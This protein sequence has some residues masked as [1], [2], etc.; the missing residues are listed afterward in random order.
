MGCEEGLFSAGSVKY[1]LMGSALKMCR[2][3][4]LGGLGVVASASLDCQPWAA[5]KDRHRITLE[6]LMPLMPE[7]GVLQVQGQPALQSLDHTRLNR[8]PVSKRVCFKTR[9]LCSPDCPGN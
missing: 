3:A 2:T 8:N 4:E 1:G 9:S 7:L 5:Q 6:S